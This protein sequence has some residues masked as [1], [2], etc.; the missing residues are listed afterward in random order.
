MC[1]KQSRNRLNGFRQS[2]G[3]ITRL[4]PGV[5]ESVKTEFFDHL[6][7]PSHADQNSTE[8]GRPHDS[9]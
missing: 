3:R 6:G 9:R 7:I 1:R 2:Y 5:N 4:K 8:A